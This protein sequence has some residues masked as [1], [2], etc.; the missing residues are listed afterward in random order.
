MQE[1]F[2]DL[3]QSLT[4]DAEPVAGVRLAELSDLD[5]QSTGEF[6]S[7]WERLPSDRRQILLE[8][9]G[10]MAD[11]QIE[12]S[13]EAINRLGLDD[14]DSAVRL[15]AIE[16]LWESEDPGLALEFLARLKADAAPEVRAAAGKALGV[17]I[18]IGETRKL[19]SGIQHGIEEALL[20]AARKDSSSEVRDLCLQT[21]GY[22]SRSE[23]AGLIEEAYAARSEG[24]LTSALRAMAHSA[25]P[26]WGENVMSRLHDPSPKIRLE[27]ARAAGEIDLREGIPDLIELLEDVDETVRRAAVWSLSQIG[28]SRATEAL[29]S[30]AEGDLDES[31]MEL[32]RDAIDN[33][34]F[35][36]GAR[37]LHTFEL[38]DPQDLRA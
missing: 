10:L 32:L 19:D 3:L 25:N 11:A 4:N 17:F 27:A 8:E 1:S 12:L 13:F 7:V 20:Q 33:L 5:A 36:D 18:L 24:R 30:M 28:G 34:A 31:E 23:V 21:L 29:N 35:V 9:L 14:L 15:Q 26:D 37:D 38:D 16:N 2:V 22:S 6:A